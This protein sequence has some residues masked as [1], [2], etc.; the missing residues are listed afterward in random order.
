MEMRELTDGEK[1]ICEKQIKRMDSELKHVEWLLEYNQLMLDK[2][3]RMNYEEKVREFKEQ[4]NAL[5]GDIQMILEKK[6]T[7]LNHI[8]NGVE[9]KERNDVP[10]GVG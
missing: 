7:M 8:K 10:I 2:G 1:R 6:R 5:M 3:L 4:K 9:V